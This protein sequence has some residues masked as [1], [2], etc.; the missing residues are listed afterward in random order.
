MVT[1]KEKLMA[2]LETA[3]I[4]YDEWNEQLIILDAG[5]VRIHFDSSGN[6]TDILGA[7]DD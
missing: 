5:Y 2:L 6:L 1:D 4:D 7:N 3:D